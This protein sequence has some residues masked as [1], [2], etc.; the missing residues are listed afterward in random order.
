MERPKTIEIPQKAYEY[1]STTGVTDL[2]KAVARLY[3]EIYRQGKESK[4]TYENVSITA[5][6]RSGLTRLAAVIG[7]INVGYFLPEYTAY[8]QM[9]GVFK[10]FV[11]I[12]TAL[13]EDTRYH[14]DSETIRKEIASRGLGAIVASNPRNPTGQV[15]HG[16]ELKELVNIAKEKHATLIM[17]EF[18]SAYIYDQEEGHTVSISRYVDDVNMD[19]VIIVDGMSKNFR[20]SEQ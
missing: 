2:R 10:R 3:N 15:I 20:V 13:E 12:P 14:I 9:L 6:G 1:A 7:D 18:Y 17:D 5:G 11:P 19:P 8:E 16:E 4:Y